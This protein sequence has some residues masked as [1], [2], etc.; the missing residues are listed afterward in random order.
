MIIGINIPF[1]KSNHGKYVLYKKGVEIAVIK[2]RGY[3]VK[4]SGLSEK[5][6]KKFKTNVVKKFCRK[7]KYLGCS[8]D[9][10]VASL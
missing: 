1:V 4:L 10:K 6:I 7:T 2:K 3:K 8:D 9:K 5:L